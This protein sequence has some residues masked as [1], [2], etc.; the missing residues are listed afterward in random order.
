T[1]PFPNSRHLGMASFA[2]CDG[3]ARTLNDTIDAG[4]YVRLMTPGGA[5]PR[6]GL[7]AAGFVP[8]NPISG[9]E[10]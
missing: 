10:F 8:E 1:A 9:N 7:S 3:S 4:V 5:R 6:P 2:F